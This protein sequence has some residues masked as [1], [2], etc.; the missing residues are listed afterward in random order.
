VIRFAIFTAVSS[1]PQVEGDS[2]DEQE[3]LCRAGAL[4]RGWQ[5]S[6]GPFVVR[7][8]SRTKWVSLTNAQEEIINPDGSRP[9]KELLDF[10]Q[11]GKVD[12]VICYS[13]DRFRDLLMQIY[14]TLKFYRCQLCSLSESFSIIP[15]EEFTPYSDD[16]KAMIIAMFQAKSSSEISTLQRRNR[17]G[18]PGRITKK[19][20]PANTISYGYRRPVGHEMDR[21]AVPEK[22]PVASHWVITIKDMYLAGQSLESIAEHL[23]KQGISAPQGGNWR[24]ETIR[25]ILRNPY[26]AGVVRWRNTRTTLDPRTGRQI[27]RAAPDAITGQGA[28]EPLWDH[29][30]YQAIIAEMARR[31]EKRYRGPH[32]TYPLSNLVVCGLC[33][34]PM[35]HVPELPKYHKEYYMCKAYRKGAPGPHARERAGDLHRR[36]VEE[37]VKQWPGLDSIEH[38]NSH[39]KRD[40]LEAALRE[41]EVRRAR[42]EEAYEN[43]LY[44]LEKASDRTAKIDKQAELLQAQLADLERT[45]LDRAEF[46]EAVTSLGGNLDSLPAW[47]VSESPEIVNGVLHKILEKVIVTGNKIELVFIEL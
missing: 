37:L 31:A 35:V 5:E 38:Q 47:L 11:A 33:G 32:K 12:V 45:S 39:N 24:G 27:T 42:I 9:I 46:E 1:K 2:L 17:L 40:E 25:Y 14:T 8:E 16:S 29:A 41:L 3:H 15:P 7:G 20:L 34:G 18:M 21:N 23:T 36:V 22:D 28:H 43:K 4:A 6:G 26:Y 13:F 30:T 44:T 10:A 19:G